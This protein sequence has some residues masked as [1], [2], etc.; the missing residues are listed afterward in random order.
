MPAA[1]PHTLLLVEDDDLSREILALHMESEGFRVLQASDGHQA[2]EMTGM[3]AIDLILLDVMMP[4]LSG[5]DVLEALRA[6][7]SHRDLP[8]IMVTARDQSEEMVSAFELG[9]NDYVTKPFDLPVVL[10]RVQ[11]QLRGREPRQA[12]A[13]MPFEAKVGTV[14]DGKYHLDAVLG[15]GYAGTVYSAH[16]VRLQRPVAIKIFNLDLDGTHDAAALAR[17]EQEGISACRVQH[18]NAVQVLDIAVAEQGVAYLVMELLEGRT[19]YQLLEEEGLMSPAQALEILSPVCDVLH[20]AHESGLV[21]RDIKPANIFLQETRYGRTV[22][23]LDFGIA[24]LMGDSGSSPT[25]SQELTVEGSIKGTPAFMAPER[26]SDESGDDGSGDIYSVAV[27]LYQ[28]LS[29]HLPFEAAQDNPVRLALMHMR[30]EPTPLR[31][32]QPPLEGPI[33]RVVMRAMA[34]DPTMRPAP[35]ALARSFAAAVADAGAAGHRTGRVV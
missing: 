34:K 15:S 3:Q 32:W 1:S 22:K 17:F 31:H 8:I 29:G 25:A 18:P 2:L 11:A 12:P 19:L 28:M 33:E 7:A 10:A 9:A 24:K 5:I 13:T 35:R 6:R 21:H 14:L 4:G 27:T 20:E 16:H 30:E 23:V 26:F